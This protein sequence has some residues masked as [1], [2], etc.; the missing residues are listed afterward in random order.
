MWL[1]AWNNL[2]S[3]KSICLWYYSQVKCAIRPVIMHELTTFF[4]FVWI[5]FYT[6]KLKFE[7]IITMSGGAMTI[8]LWR[9]ISIFV[10][11]EGKILIKLVYCFK[12]LTMLIFHLLYVI[13]F[14]MKMYGNVLLITENVKLN[15]SQCLR[16]PARLV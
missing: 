5:V 6:K 8:Q 2:I 3:K 4:L 9:N 13:R 14:C 11:Y 16:C 1:F 10:S 7:G 12:I 15:I